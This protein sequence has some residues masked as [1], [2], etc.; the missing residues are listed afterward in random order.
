MNNGDMPAT[1]VDRYT[2]AEDVQIEGAE[3]G[4]VSSRSGRS[5][6]FVLHRRGGEL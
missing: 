1:A 6:S 5:R 3:E 4:T 2:I